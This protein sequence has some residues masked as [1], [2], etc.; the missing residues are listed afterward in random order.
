MPAKAKVGS[1]LEGSSAAASEAY[2]SSGSSA[3]SSGSEAGENEVTQTRQTNG[4]VV[5]DESS[6]DEDEGSERD[7]VVDWD[8]LLPKLRPAMMDRSKKR[9]AAFVSRYL[10][11]TDEG[12]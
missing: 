5:N 3:S 7:E 2:E 4:F 9:R 8:V 1:W 11:V 12:V 6:D 10:T